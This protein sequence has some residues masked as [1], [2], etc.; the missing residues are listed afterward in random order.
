MLQRNIFSHFW[1][2]AW[3][4]FLALGWLLPNHYYPWV[5]FHTDAW[6]SSLFAIAAIVVF[7][8]V[9]DNVQWHR[10]PVVVGLVIVLPFLQYY[11]GLIPF[12]GQA[13][14]AGAYLLG[15]LLAM[16]MGA[17]WEKVQPEQALDGLL[18]AI[19]VASIVSVGLQLQQWLQLDGLEIWTI[20]MAGSRPFANLGQPN[21]LATLLIWGLIACAWGVYK[22]SIR[23]PIALLM[24][25]FL[26]FGVVLTQS[27]TA[28]ICV[29]L[30]IVAAWGWR[31][32]WRRKS[33]PWVISALA[34]YFF[35]MV[36]ALPYLTEWLVPGVQ[37]RPV[38][39]ASGQLRLQ[40]YWLFIDAAFEKPLWGYGWS[41]LPK[42]QILLAESHPKLT[43]FFIHSHNL[44]LDLILWCGIPIGLTLSSILVLWL[45]NSLRQVRSIPDALLMFFLIAIAVHAMLEL[46]LHYAYFL[47]PTG[48]VV[49]VMNVR[50]KKHV[51][52]VTPLWSVGILLLAG[53]TLLSAIV[54]DYMMVEANFLAFRF[55]VARVGTQPVGTPPNVLVLTHLREFIKMAREQ[56]HSKM[57]EEEIEWMKSV[58]YQFPSRSNL[59]NVAKALALNGRSAEAQD[60][61][62]KIR[63]TM[64]DV[65]YSE[66]AEVWK[67]QV[68]QYPVLTTVNWRIQS[69]S[70]SN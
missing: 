7:T 43:G 23:Q 42:A 46:P 29:A 60:W 68:A 32:L 22:G 17:Q 59:F 20:G 30:G 4:G 11:A 2:N 21:Q 69:S 39:A 5:A 50:L 16:L 31:D 41:Q 57:E 19:G 6:I 52:S 13:W 37:L 55:E 38:E 10:L 51:V 15:L 48:I 54:R 33:T 28:W 26:I 1:L 36:A 58:S 35:I 64:S 66:L 18:V 49:G 40:A 45:T 47:L 9:K 12:A 24:S 8:R 34:A 61:L 44:F 3:A 63:R 67:G 62:D 27:R 65:E 56:P 14:T 53:I 70:S 25:I